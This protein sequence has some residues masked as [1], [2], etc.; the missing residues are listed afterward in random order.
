MTSSSETT[1]GFSRRSV[2]V[3]LGAAATLAAC[4]GG[5]TA[6]Q[7]AGGG[8]RHMDVL[9]DRQRGRGADLAITRGLDLGG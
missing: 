1:T 3:G 9:R 2:M 5:K 8:G 4:G 6:D 7:A